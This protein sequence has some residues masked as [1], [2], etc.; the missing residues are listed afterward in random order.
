MCQILTEYA[1]ELSEIPEKESLLLVGHGPV[2]ELNNIMW[3]R[4]LERI[5]SEIKKQL[6]FREIFC[7]TLR[8]DSADLIR[9][10]ASKTLRET[11][12]RL[13]KEGNVIVVSYVLGT[14]M[15]QE[16]VKNILKEIPS[17][18]ISSKGIA[19]HPLA[20]EWVEETIS[21]KMDQPK[22]TPVNTHWGH[23][24]WV[25]GK[26]YGTIRYGLECD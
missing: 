2:D 7:M 10:Q 17:V 6:Y 22:V 20:V 11:A 16:E 24:D 15:V 18:A 12:L 1:K 19:N 26:P 21:K 8:N 4:Q 14:V 25:K 5:G 9:E 13:S 3:V 23:L